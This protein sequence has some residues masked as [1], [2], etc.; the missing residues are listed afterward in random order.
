ML[1]LLSAVSAA[2]AAPVNFTIPCVDT[3]ADFHGDPAGADLVVF[4]GGNEWFAMPHILAAFQRTHPDVR[5][6]FYETLPPGVLAE[7]IHSGAIRV[8]DFILTVQPDVYIAG[9]RR[10]KAEERQ[11]VVERPVLFASNSLGIIVKRGNPEHINGLVD[12]QRPGVR[13]AMPNPKTEGI[14]RQIELAYKKAGGDALVHAI[15]VTKLHNG[16]TMLTSIHH[17]ESPM[18]ILEGKADAGPVWISEA[19]Y[20]ER[21]HSGIMA[22]RIP[23]RDNVTGLYLAAVLKHAAHP[24]AAREFTSFLASPQAQAIYRSYGFAAGR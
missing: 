23:E 13:I 18:W 14:A 2:A 22:I 20:Q 10:M 15:M 7:Q 21:I 12:F 5:K 24:K 6:I 9:E 3:M 1:F 4:V 19:L 8:G 11:S 16:T 17:R